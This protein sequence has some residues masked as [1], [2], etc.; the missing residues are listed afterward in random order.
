MQD[1]SRVRFWIGPSGWS[2]ADWDGIVYPQSKPRGFKPLAHIA[3]YFNAVE[4]NSSFYRIPAAR[5]TAAW[6]R[7]VPEEFRFAV[8]LTQI[9]THERGEF[10]PP[11]RVREFSEGVGPLRAAGKL[12]PLL[13][14]FPWSFRYGPEAVEWLR[15]LADSFGDFERFIEVRHA[16]WADPQALGEL[17]KAGGYCNIDQPRLRDCLGPTQ[18][19][20]GRSAYVRLHGRNSRNWFANNQPAFE[21]YNYLYSDEELRE[22]VERLNA[23]ATEAENIYL[24]A[25]NHYR[26]QGTV[27]A[28]ELKAMLTGGPVDVP[29][30]LTRA[31]PRLNSVARSGPQRGLFGQPL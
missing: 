1:A 26:G 20:F 31:Y 18:H 8:K 9:F 19:V 28:L 10:P 22:W 13:M 17:R 27:N 21:R 5:M 25:N 2:Y 30:E 16:S 12:G 11:A 4:V 14:Q 23:M 29:P 15:R 6:P 24:F 7:Q 3:R